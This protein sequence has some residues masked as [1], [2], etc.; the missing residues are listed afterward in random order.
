M[1][2]MLSRLLQQIY[3]GSFYPLHEDYIA[4]IG[5]AKDWGVSFVSDKGWITASGNRMSR[6]W[7]CQQYFPFLS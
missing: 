6:I 7:M 1:D 5:F 2:V 3:T 4:I